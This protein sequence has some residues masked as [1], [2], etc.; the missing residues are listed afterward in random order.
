MMFDYVFSAHP[1]TPTV[2]NRSDL[3][4]EITMEARGQAGHCCDHPNR[5]AESATPFLE[6]VFQR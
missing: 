1:A 6:R 4:R 2:P 3:T 5:H